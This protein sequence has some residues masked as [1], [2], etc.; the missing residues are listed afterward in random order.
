M[1]RRIVLIAA[2]VALVAVTGCL[3]NG[4]DD[5]GGSMWTLPCEDPVP[6]VPPGM[7]VS[8]DGYIVKVREGLDVAIE[9]ARIETQCAIPVRDVY[10]NIPYFTTS[11]LDDTGITCLRCDPAVEQISPIVIYQPF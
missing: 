8:S 4:G 7:G 10:S 6:F 2:F 9:A 1:R 11:P 3:S 5:D